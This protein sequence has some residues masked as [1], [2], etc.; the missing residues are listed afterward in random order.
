[1]GEISEEFE[2]ITGDRRGDGCGQ[3]RSKA[4][5]VR[6]R[7]NV[8]DEHRQIEVLKECGFVFGPNPKL[9]FI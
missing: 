2:I 9:I 6:R 3:H 4:P 5:G 7:H 1:M 8:D